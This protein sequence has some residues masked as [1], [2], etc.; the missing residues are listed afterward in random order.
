M[1]GVKRPAAA[2]AG[3]AF[4]HGPFEGVGPGLALVVFDASPRTSPL[5]EGLALDAAGRGS[6]VVLMDGVG[7]K[8]LEAI[9]T[10]RLPR[11]GAEDD[12]SLGLFPVLA[13]RS[14]NLLLYALAS[15]LGVEAGVF[16]YGGKITS[17]E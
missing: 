2:F 6:P 13:A 9:S 12:D 3:G 5:V 4:R 8:A 7:S 17:K 14:H 10:V 1:E 15:R 11:L 16:R